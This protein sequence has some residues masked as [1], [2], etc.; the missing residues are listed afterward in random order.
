MLDRVAEGRIARKHHIVCRDDAGQL[1]HEEC[2]T[3]TGFDGPYTIVYHQHRPH[4]QA[5]AQMQHGWTLPKAAPERALAKR[6]YRSQ[7]LPPRGGPMVNA[8]MPLLFN[9]DVVLS[10][11]HPTEPD[12]VYFVNGD[13]DDLYYVFKG[14]GVVRSQFGDLPYT[15][16][17]YVC[18][19]RGILHRWLPDPGEPQ[20]LLSMEC[21]GG[22]GLLQQWRN[23]VGQLRMDA[24]YC[25]RD[26]TVSSF[27]GAQEENIRQLLLKKN[28]AFHAFEYEHSPLDVV[29]FDGTVLPVGLPHPQL[30][31][32]RWPGAPAAYLAR[33]L[34]HPWS[35]HLQLRAAHGRLPP[36]GHPVPL[37]PCLGRLR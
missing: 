16:D 2:L 28:G 37:S 17:D 19:P 32:A 6:H 35:P 20:V 26:F 29:G 15:A 12:P 34:R 14:K 3:R 10:M 25:H 13:A 8:R 18:L 1:L 23:E 31:A 9:D 36:R 27:K 22:L 24:P 4:T 5:V 21:M 33:H 7:D 11:A 30:P